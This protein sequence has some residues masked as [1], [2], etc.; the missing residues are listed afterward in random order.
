MRNEN[1]HGITTLQGFI[2]PSMPL[3]IT[4]MGLHAYHNYYP[5]LT[6]IDPLV[7]MA[8]ICSTSKRLPN[9]AIHL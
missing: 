7:T 5:T 3:D 4:L 8:T 6:P 9:I 2:V 1:K